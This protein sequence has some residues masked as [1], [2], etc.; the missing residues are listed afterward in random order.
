SFGAVLYEMATGTLPFRGDTSAA[1]FNSILNKAPTPPSR[2]NAELPVELERLINKALEKD[3]DVRC[4]SAAEMRAYRK[5]VK[6]D[7]SSG[8]IRPTHDSAISG[9]PH[10][11]AAA[12]A[13]A[14][15]GTSDRSAAARDASD[16][17]MVAT[18]ARR[19]GKTL[20]AFL[21][22]AVV[23]VVVLAYLLRP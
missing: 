1:I 14:A 9:L 8:R 22:A 11:D 17:Q 19:H 20:S 2:L 10:T 3:R 23:A 15:A 5:R 21:G 16:S 4:Q 12:S 13:G 18:L 7:T 6:R